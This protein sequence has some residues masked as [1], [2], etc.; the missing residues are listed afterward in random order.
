M[1]AGVV[2]VVAAG[3]DGSEIYGGDGSIGKSNDIVPAV[4][5]EVATISALNDQDGSPVS[6]DYQAQV[7]GLSHS[8]YNYN[9]ELDQ[10]NPDTYTVN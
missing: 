10:D 3:N 4:Y 7:T 1:N 5:P 6:G 2:Y 9:V 8:S